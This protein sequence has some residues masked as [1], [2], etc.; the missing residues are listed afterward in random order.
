MLLILAACSQP[1]E[2]P[3]ARIPLQP[4]GFSMS[5]MTGGAP[6]TVDFSNLI[7]NGDTFLW[8]FGDETTGNE[9]E[10]SHTYADPGVYPVSLTV[11]REAGGTTEAVTTNQTL[12]V[13]RGLLAE[14]VI[15]PPELVLGPTET[16]KP[17]ARALD[18]FGNEMT[19]LEVTWDISEGG[20]FS[21][22]GTL[23]A[24][25]KAGAF[26]DVVTAEATLGVT[27][28]RASASVTVVPGPLDRL[29]VEPLVAEVDINGTQ[30][31]KVRGLDP[32]GNEVQDLT[33][34]WTLPAEA[35]RADAD[36]T[37]RASTTAGTFSVAVLAT[38][39][40]LSAGS[41]VVWVV[42]PGPLH[43]LTLS[44]ERSLIEAGSV[45]QFEAAPVDSYGNAIHDISLVWT[46]S[47]TIG[48]VDSR[49][50]FRARTIAGASGEIT[51]K[52]LQGERREEAVAGV[53]IGPSQ[54]AGLSATPTS[55]EV[56]I[57][58]LLPIA[59]DPHDKFGN[60]IED[61]TLFFSIPA[62]LGDSIIYQTGMLVAG[63]QLGE[64]DVV[65]T[66]IQGDIFETVLSKVVV[67]GSVDRIELVP[68]TL[69]VPTTGQTE[70]DVR[71]FDRLGNEISGV[72]ASWAVVNR[73][74]TIDTA[75]IFSAGDEPGT[76]VDTVEVTV[77]N[78]GTTL[79]ATATVTVETGAVAKAS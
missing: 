56:S 40:E 25:S 1:S 72:D 63:E 28:R 36:G 35:G 79:R 51:V 31:F 77:T 3:S 10:P 15:D 67:P 19:G 44:P 52:A 45:H 74:G 55:A 68:A 78:R 57:G 18:Q 73:G 41:A 69:T 38:R 26:R 43:H 59:A 30:V 23:I 34:D 37:L 54:L 50:M 13:Y 11:F 9:R 46:A 48:I 65:V 16:Q 71:A 60:R 61:L 47:G 20:H 6:L 58:H 75:G 62:A 2:A 17:T 27:T 24:G 22:D 21:K 53:T 39:G 29:V 32:F 7:S 42:R 14:I 12:V 4:M 5:P 8:D 49:G 33:Y 66:A 76:F 70:F 64:V